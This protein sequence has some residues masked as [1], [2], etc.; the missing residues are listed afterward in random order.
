MEQI[1]EKEQKVLNWMN[2]LAEEILYIGE[3]PLKE[4]YKVML[5]F[6][7]ADIVSQVWNMA[8][9]D[10]NYNHRKKSFI[11]WSE[12]F[13][14]KGDHY[15]RLKKDDLFH[16]TG[17][18]F[19][20]IRCSLLHFASV[21]NYQDHPILI[22]RDSISFK[23]IKYI[24]SKKKIEKCTVLNSRELFAILARNFGYF[25]IK[26]GESKNIIFSLKRSMKKYH[27]NRAEKY[28]KLFA[29]DP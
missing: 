26:I 20:E 27:L 14:F 28:L 15:E 6:V 21:P 9:N 19:Y 10:E 8:E 2:E 29:I 23:K 17:D 24:R 7:F 5:F 12:E 25:V 1:E 3:S 22:T 4:K 16:V 11:K 18:I 13:F